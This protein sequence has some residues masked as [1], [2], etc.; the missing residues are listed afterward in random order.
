MHTAG[1]PPNG[2]V[3]IPARLVDESPDNCP[4]RKRKNSALA[5]SGARVRCSECAT[6]FLPIF[7]YESC[8]YWCRDTEVQKELTVTFR[9]KVN[10][11]SSLRS[12][13]TPSCIISWSLL[14]HHQLV[15]ISVS[16]VVLV[17]EDPL[18]AESGRRGRSTSLW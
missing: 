16:V 12:S 5:T 13:M 17:E 14:L 8:K 6:L 11:P 1:R 3:W 9:S 2:A 10:I 4:E 18:L 15:M 7:L